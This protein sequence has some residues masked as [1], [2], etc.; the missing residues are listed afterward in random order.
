MRESELRYWEMIKPGCM[1][2]ESDAEEGERIVTH[3]LLWR[4]ECEPPER[5]GLAL[6]LASKHRL[7]VLC[8]L[9]GGG[10]EDRHPP[11]ALEIRV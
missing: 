1:T 8:S 5:D 10:G 7:E 3:Q 2:E 4:S 6:R 11:A 9:E